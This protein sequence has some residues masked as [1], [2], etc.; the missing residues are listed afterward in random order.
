LKS[1]IVHGKEDYEILYHHVREVNG[2]PINNICHPLD[3]N[4]EVS[5]LIV[6]TLRSQVELVDGETSSDIQYVLLLLH[7]EEGEIMMR[8]E[9]P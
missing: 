5:S 6:E 2:I 3:K 7:F 1:F 4:N 8:R 9:K